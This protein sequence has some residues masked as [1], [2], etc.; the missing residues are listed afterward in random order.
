MIW[1]L[2]DTAKIIGADRVFHT[3]KTPPSVKPI[4]TFWNFGASKTLKP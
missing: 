2:I 4:T 1:V 3:T